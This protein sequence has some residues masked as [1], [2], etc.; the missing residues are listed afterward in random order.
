MPLGNGALW[1]D[2]C[3]VQSTQDVSEYVSFEKLATCSAA[4][5]TWCNLGMSNVLSFP[6]P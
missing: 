1:Y 6:G 2:E 4:A 5:F 3:H